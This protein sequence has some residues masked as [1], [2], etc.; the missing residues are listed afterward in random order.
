MNQIKLNNGGRAE[1]D[2]YYPRLQVNKHGEIVLS[3]FKDKSGLTHGILVGKTA[4]N[5]STTPIGQNFSDWEVAGLLV[6]YDGEVQASFI[7]KV[8]TEAFDEITCRGAGYAGLLTQR[9]AL[10]ENDKRRDPLTARIEPLV[11]ER[12]AIMDRFENRTQL[13]GDKTRLAEINRELY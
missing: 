1:G 5:K 6:D 10:P 7:N 8:P 2:L 12:D 13:V 4:E 11:A 9:R 3:I